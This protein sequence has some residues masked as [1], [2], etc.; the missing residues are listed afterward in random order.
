MNR[1]LT[2]YLVFTLALA[3]LNAN[4]GMWL[5]H[6]LNENNMQEMK[7]L[8]CK[9]TA[10]EIYSI[11][12]SSIK[13]AVVVFGGGCTGEIVSSNGLIFTNHH[14]GFDQIQNHSTVENDYL[15]NGFWAKSMEEELPNPGLSVKFLVEIN[16]VSQEILSDLSDTLTEFQ[17]KMKISV[18]SDS[19]VKSE[20]DTNNYDI[21]IKPFF[22][23]N[24]YLM[25][26]YKVYSDVRLVGA[27]PSSIGKFG[28][29]TDNWMWPRHTADF[30]IFRVYTAPDGSPASYSKENVPLKPKKSLKIST[31]GI[32]EGDYAMVIGYPGSTSRYLTSYGLKE[33]IEVINPNRI[34]TRGIRQN[35]WHEH[36]KDNPEVYIK[37]ATK[38]SRS[39]NYWKNSIGQNKMFTRM[40]VLS[41]KEEYE[42]K[43]ESWVNLDSIRIKKYQ[44]ILPELE[45]AYAGRRRHIHHLQNIY[46]SIY[47]SMDVMRFA[48][49]I[50]PYV[51]I[52]KNDDVENQDSI[53]TEMRDIAHEHFGEFDFSTDL[54]MAKTMVHQYH[55]NVPII[56]QPELIQKLGRKSPGDFEK[57]FDKIYAKSIFT[58]TN[59][60][61]K[62][63][64]K[65]KVSLLANDPIFRL[66]LEFYN[67][68]TRIVSAKN[69]YDKRI[70]ADNRI[71]MK[72]I[73]EMETS[74]TLYPDANF[75]MRLTYGTVRSYKPADAV[76]YDYFTTLD[77]ILE[78]EDS[79]S[80]EFLVPHQ[81]KQLIKK[82]DYKPYTTDT[83]MLACFITDNDITGGNSGSPVLNANGELIGIAFD[84]NWEGMC[85]DVVFNEQY[86]RCIAVDIRYVLFIIDKFAGA[87][88]IIEELE[89][90]H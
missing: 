70:E 41:A 68:S 31:K 9:L 27:P 52:L 21:I 65:P 20:S 3:N 35:V 14:C 32:K 1:L 22:Q 34:Q 75:S 40:N 84:G 80:I 82:G 13:D 28:Y 90:I 29:D 2:S 73:M 47:G 88:N 5:M 45:K 62:F 15:A 36:M 74:K 17:R 50:K 12:K 58:D 8:G 23:G 37:Y 85:G 6:L 16:D 69:K 46:E 18:I 72:G 64:S 76:F 79:T 77:G 86:Q 33:K 59:R 66:Y 25:L 49:K 81:L 83:T 7:S 43:F 19:L 78:K 57:F 42:R 60:F 10:E 38:Y 56:E 51:S 26:K 61:K 67:T 39:S 89:I 53:V 24:Q 44:T 71:L 55:K 48:Y 11:N 4:E 30:A 63:I 54:Q 87:K